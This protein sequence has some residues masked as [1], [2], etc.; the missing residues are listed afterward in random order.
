MKWTS[1]NLDIVPLLVF[2]TKKLNKIKRSRK[3]PSPI[4][5]PP[6]SLRIQF[7]SNLKGRLNGW[8]NSS[9]TVLS[10]RYY[11]THLSNTAKEVIRDL[12]TEITTHERARSLQLKKDL[13]SC[14]LSHHF[15]C[16]PVPEYHFRCP[17]M[18][19]L[20][21]DPN[22][23]VEKD[24]MSFSRSRDFLNHCKLITSHLFFP[25]KLINSLS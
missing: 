2:F 6:T 11:S 5:M 25:T 23:L 18:L 12:P 14:F 10:T 9:C 17:A 24:G 8:S 20:E 21:F 13:L 4:S 22:K 7:Q 15:N 1:I 3:P 16:S 19:V